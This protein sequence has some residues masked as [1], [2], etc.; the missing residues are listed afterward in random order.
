MVVT[1]PFSQPVWGVPRCGGRKS[2]RPH[3]HRPTADRYKLMAAPDQSTGTCATLL[4]VLFPV[5]R[6]PSAP[7]PTLAR[8][9]SAIVSCTRCP[10]LRSYC[11]HVAREKRAAYRHEDTGGSPCPALAIPRGGCSCWAWRLRRMARIVQGRVFTGD[12]TGGS[13]DFLMAALHRAGFANRT[14]ST[15]ATDGLQLL[16]AYI[17]AAVRCAPPDNKPLPEEIAA[18]ADHLD[19]E[20]A[21]LSRLQIVVALGKIA[22]DA[23]LQHLAR[24]GS[25]IRPRPAFG[26]GVVFDLASRS[27]GAAS[28]SG[29]STRGARSTIGT[30]IGCYHPSRQERQPRR[31]DAVDLR[32]H[33]HDGARSPAITQRSFAA[34]NCRRYHHGDDPLPASDG[35]SFAAAA[36]RLRRRPARGCELR[37]ARPDP[38]GQLRLAQ[39]YEIVAS[40]PSRGIRTSGRR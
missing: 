27:E 6:M 15:H 23:G 8:V 4:S 29:A 12:G 9:T 14:T 39:H 33:L 34:S 16:D 40:F 2:R 25:T 10:R 31:S 37:V 30:L 5:T 24:K 17:I 28:T 32:R 18:C 19:A 20:L 13:G 1:D 36:A 35:F 26:H 22:W 21:A 7:T 3:G 38:F 11:Q